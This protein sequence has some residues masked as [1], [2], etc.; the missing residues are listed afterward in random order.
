MAVAVVLRL[1]SSN[2]TIVHFSR[3]QSLI[4]YISI[5]LVTRDA[6][7]GF[8]HALFLIFFFSCPSIFRAYIAF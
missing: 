5:A 7:R 1:G 3:S 2:L 8:R 4:K 6:T